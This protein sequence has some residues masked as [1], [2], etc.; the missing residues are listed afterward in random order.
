MRSAIVTLALSPLASS[1][2]FSKPRRLV[3]STWLTHIPFAMYLVD[4]LRPKVIVELGT[5]AGASYCAFCQAVQILGIEARCY[6]I[7]T[8]QGDPQSGLYGAHVLAD[9]RSHH[10]ALYGDFSRLFQCSFDDAL[11]TFNDASIDLLHIDGLHTY[12][13][14]RHDFESW[15]PKLSA[16][17]VVLFHD[18]A[19]HEDDF[20]A[21]RYWAEIKERYPS[22]EVQYGCGL[23][24]LAV[25]SMAKDPLAELLNAT[26]EE[27][28]SME[29][30]FGSLGRRWEL[31]HELK[32]L[33]WVAKQQA[34]TLAWFQE[35]LADYQKLRRLPLVRFLRAWSR[36]GVMGAGTRAL[37][38]VWSRMRGVQ[39]ES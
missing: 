35:E 17:G 2:V 32:A 14:V 20:G 13:A 16:H 39:P 24:V 23:G 10:D 19:V 22:F 11:S 27:R 5:Y 4:V 1:V 21:W 33:K 8:W 37:G 31:E 26:P 12:E 28:A 3:H 29:Q 38:R 25:G 7:D 30:F 9:L 6:A 36:Y 34:E 18:I 15:F